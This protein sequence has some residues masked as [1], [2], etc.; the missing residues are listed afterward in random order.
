MESFFQQ[1]S[2]FTVCI[3]C[4]YS[5]YLFTICDMP[6]A[7]YACYSG[8]VCSNLETAIQKF[9][10]K[11]DSEFARIEEETEEAF[12]DY[13]ALENRLKEFGKIST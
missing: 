1:S 13:R 11:L 7:I 8:S 2:Y 4:S 10:E 9:E 6:F 12:E 5:Y 3:L